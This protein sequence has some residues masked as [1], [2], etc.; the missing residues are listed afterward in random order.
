MTI[1]LK[2]F[3]K[4][5]LR[6][7][8]EAVEELQSEGKPYYNPEFRIHVDQNKDFR[9]ILS[10]GMYNYS[11]V[12][13]DVAATSEKSGD[14]KGTAGIWVVSADLSGKLSQQDVSRIK[15]TIPVV[16]PTIGET[17]KALQSPSS[18]TP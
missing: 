9:G 1:E 12:E 15:F 7:V 8:C 13:F 2:D 16:L 10:H 6:S 11:F 4:N 3:I 18:K 14:L 17:R 5:A